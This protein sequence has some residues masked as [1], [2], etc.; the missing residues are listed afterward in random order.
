MEPLEAPIPFSHIIKTSWSEGFSI[1]PYWQTTRDGSTAGDSFFSPTKVNVTPSITLSSAQVWPDSSI[2]VML[3]IH[4]VI[5]ISNSWGLGALE[6]KMSKEASS[7]IVI[8]LISKMMDDWE[9]SCW[10]DRIL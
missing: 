6:S 1:S 4:K 5:G 9:Y 2:L 3:N 8:D 10:L 7:S